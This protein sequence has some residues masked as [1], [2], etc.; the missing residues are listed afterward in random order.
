MSQSTCKEQVHKLASL[1]T[2]DPLTIVAIAYTESSCGQH[3]LGDDSKSLGVLQLQVPTVRDVIRWY[4]N[5]LGHLSHM[6]DARLRT[7]LLTNV[8][9]QVKVASLFY[10]HYKQLKGKTYAIRRYN[11]YIPYYWR[12]YKRVRYYENL[13]LQGK[14]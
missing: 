12:Y 11:G 7:I 13:L 5:Q 1:Y 3:I 4:P 8:H 14:L 9:I 2:S 10:E 6:S